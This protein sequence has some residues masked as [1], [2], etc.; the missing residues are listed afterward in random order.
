MS[1]VKILKKKVES[2]KEEDTNQQEVQAGAENPNAEKLKQ[3]Q[4][5]KAQLGKEIADLEKKCADDIAQKKQL[6]SQLDKQIADLGGNVEITESNEI[7]GLGRVNESI[8]SD[9]GKRDEISAIL[10]EAIDNADLSYTFTEKECDNYAR[11]LIDKMNDVS[12]TWKKSEDNWD[13]FE[14][15]LVDYKKVKSKFGSSDKEM[16]RL[17]ESLKKSFYVKA[18]SYTWVFGND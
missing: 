15:I 2:L 11:Y 3:L 16:A 18:N 1:K 8:Y 13:K 7:V 14:E 17:K 9:N 6:I 5:Q 12:S 10:K 4:G